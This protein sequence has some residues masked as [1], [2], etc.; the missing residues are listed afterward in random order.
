MPFADS[1]N[2][3]DCVQKRMKETGYNRDTAEKV[4]GKMKAELEKSEVK[5]WTFDP[6]E[7]LKSKRKITGTFHKPEI[8]KDGEY[9]T[10]D[11]IRKSIP[12]YMHL[13]ALHDFPHL[14]QYW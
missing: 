12:D 3:E 8:D 14:V 7:I 9:I 1:K 13:P 4:C 2:F 5:E 6:T 10:S 11:A